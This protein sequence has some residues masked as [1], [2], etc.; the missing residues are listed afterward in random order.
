MKLSP[1]QT[2][3][4]KKPQSNINISDSCT[5]FLENLVTILVEFFLPRIQVKFH[6]D[7]YN[8]GSE[9]YTLQDI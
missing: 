7:Q 1:I 3:D 9:N 2:T 8:I 4:K 5:L 6:L